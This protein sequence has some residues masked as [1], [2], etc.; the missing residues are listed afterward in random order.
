MGLVFGKYEAKE[1]GFIPGGASLHNT[2]TAHGPEME[3]FERASQVELKPER[4]ADDALAVMFESSLMMNPTEYALNKMTYD[5]D[6]ISVSWKG[7][8]KHFKPP[9]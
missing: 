5:K 3:V 4:I 9:Q 2:M 8:K 7:F 6:Y 1:K